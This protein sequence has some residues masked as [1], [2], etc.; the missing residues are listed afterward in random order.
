MFALRQSPR[1]R[2]PVAAVAR[3]AAI[4]AAVLAGALVGGGPAPCQAAPAPAYAADLAAFVKE[5]DAGYPFFELKGIK[6][7]WAA[8]RKRLAAGVGRCRSDTD[9]LGLIVEGMRC[10]RDAHMS[11]DE[12]KAEMPKPP[13]EYVSG[14]SFLPAIKNSVVV[15]VPPKGM[16]SQ[17][18]TGTVV[19]TID[20]KPARAVLDELAKRSWAAGGFFSSPQRARLFEYRIPLRGKQ[21]EKHVI[22]YVARGKPARITLTSTV[23]AGGWPHVYNQPANLARVGRSFLYGRLPGGSGYIYIRRVEAD[24]ADGLKEAL[25]KVPGAKGW[26]VDLCGNGGGG[27]DDTLIAAVKAMPRPVAVIIDEGCI[28]AGE[29]LARDF[30]EYAGARLFGAKT[31][32]S[33]SSKRHWTFPSGI[34]SVT[35]STRSRWR[36]DRKPIEFNGIDPDEPVEAVPEE[37]ARGLNSA[38]CRAEA[39]LRKP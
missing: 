23:E 22:G 20:G 27:Y 9:F 24:T 3:A 7:D 34:A 11:L 33:S 26:V 37:L 8:T 14:I 21:G 5:V 12:P 4:V 15:M 16:E 39:Y 18:A 25:A 30:A 36:G 19:L 10:L 32:G 35:F 28:S 1:S 2:R 29:T 38:I 31:A 17:L 6:D 13:P